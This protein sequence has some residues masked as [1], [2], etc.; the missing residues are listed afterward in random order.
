VACSPD[1]QDSLLELFV[2]LIK[3]IPPLRNDL[4]FER[5]LV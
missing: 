1:S 4:R 3:K 2:S 5:Q